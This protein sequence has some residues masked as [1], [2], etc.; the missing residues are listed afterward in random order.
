MTVVDV[1]RLSP[2]PDFVIRDEG[3][4][5][6]VFA[7]WLGDLRCVFRPNNQVHELLDLEDCR[8]FIQSQLEA[9]D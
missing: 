5:W 3:Q 1:P 4:G 7:H 9:G 8:Q 6:S 2:I